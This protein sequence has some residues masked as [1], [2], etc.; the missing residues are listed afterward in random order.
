MIASKKRVAVIGAGLAGIAVSIRLAKKG[1]DVSVYEKSPTFGGKLGF[2]QTDQFRFDKGPSLFTNPEEVD[3]LFEICGK[4]PR[5]FFNYKKHDRSCTYF[6]PDKTQVTFYSD[7][8]ELKTEISSRFSS[9]EAHKV[10]TYLERS[11]QTYERIGDFFVDHPPV[12]LKDVFRK[13]LL[14]RYP[15]FLTAKLRKT[16]HRYNHS[17]LVNPKLVQIF[18]RYGTYNGSNPYKMS[19]IYSMIPHLEQNKGTFFPVGGMRSIVSSLY[20]LAVNEGVKFHFQSNIKEIYIRH[21]GYELLME[22][23]SI[24]CDKLI[25]AIDHLTFYRDLLK[26]EKLF[27]H[28]SKQERS[29]SGIVFYWG[30][31]KKQI[32]L[33]L[34]SII[35]SED[36]R[37]EFDQ[38]FIKKKIPDD[39]TIYIHLSSSIN[40]EDAPENGQNWF[41]MI[42]TPAGIQPDENEITEI[43]KRVLKKI[44]DYF[45][46]DIETNIVFE[47]VWTANE[48]EQETGSF[49]GALYGASSNSKLAALRRHGNKQKRYP[50]LY[51]CGGTVHPGGGIPLVL[52]SAKIVSDLIDNE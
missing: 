4:N 52:K 1:Y 40:A 44:S 46:S 8:D 7:K 15:H 9:A 25:C 18:N 30:M 26:D 21:Q 13:D 36:Y 45:Q 16:L 23:S 12:K 14:V 33:S 34:H 32:D 10:L 41:V 17:A 48:I 3:E 20:Q 35:F 47:D 31:K 49:Q 22:D 19:G 51:F 50:G 39:P 37:K 28:Y 38:I 2:I 11:K 5:D 43:R 24:S 6:F 42:N 29:S 27:K